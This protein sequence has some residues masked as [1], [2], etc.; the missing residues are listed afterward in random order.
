MGT[1]RPR[2]RACRGGRGGSEAMMGLF[3]KPPTATP[4]SLRCEIAQLH[5]AELA[6]ADDYLRLAVELPQRTADSGRALA[7]AY[8][9][10]TPP[11]P[12]R[13]DL[14]AERARLDELL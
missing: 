6:M 3:S 1:A 4:E 11:L 8:L 13:P 12:N 14:V 2:P 5:Q 7:E 9:R 10:N